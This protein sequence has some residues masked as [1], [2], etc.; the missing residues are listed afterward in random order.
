MSKT[1]QDLRTD[2]GLSQ[3]Q[4]AKKL[5]I[6]AY[7]LVSNWERAKS[8]PNFAHIRGL[9]K[10]YGLKTDDI[11][12]AIEATKVSHNETVSQKNAG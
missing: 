3:S 4:V 1:L 9:A 11:I 8:Q 7:Q 6:K 10:L 5:G 12:D 2:A